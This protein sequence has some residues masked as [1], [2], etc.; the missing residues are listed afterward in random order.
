MNNYIDGGLELKPSIESFDF[1]EKTHPVTNFDPVLLMLSEPSSVLDLITGDSLKGFIFKLNVQDGKSSY[2][3]FNL[4]EKKQVEV[5]HFALKFVVISDTESSLDKFD[6]NNK[7]T[8][9]AE[10]FKTEAKMQQEIWKQTYLTYG[11]E[12]APSVGNITFLE[13][14]EDIIDLLEY[15]KDR[16]V[17]TTQ[18]AIEVIDYLKN[19]YE[20]NKGFKLGI[21]L[22]KNYENSKPYYE[23]FE[24][25]IDLLNTSPADVLLA[26]K[27]KYL[28]IRQK[29]LI[30]L[31]R[32][33][34][35]G[36]IHLD[37]H[38]GNSLNTED[39]CVIIDYGKAVSIK[40]DN[41]DFTIDKYKRYMLNK[42]SAW[43]I[44]DRFVYVTD[45]KTRVSYYLRRVKDSF[46]SLFQ[47]LKILEGHVKKRFKRVTTQDTVNLFDTI[48]KSIETIDS[49]TYG[50]SF[51]DFSSQ[52]ENLIDNFDD[53]E[54][55]NKSMDLNELYGGDFA[56]RLVKEMKYANAKEPKKKNRNIYR[57]PMVDAATVNANILGKKSKRDTRSWAPV[58]N[59]HGGKT[60]KKTASRIVKS[61][62]HTN[63]KMMKIKSSKSKSKKKQI[64]I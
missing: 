62:F 8:D 36:Y 7:E 53:D 4:E 19:V 56:K 2:T 11:G 60:I 54:S 6:G 26:A 28:N 37:F 31:L 3:E 30:K 16:G 13:G 24:E 59:K 45:R 52:M 32:L 64:S 29:T 42:N 25:Y 49:Y 14:S 17:N 34:L 18:E 5:T 41:H 61:K 12:I 55:A 57:I 40:K 39:S 21:L 35:L 50:Y 9:T 27:K 10:L 1:D 20:I 48:I 47:G 51:R 33:A 46:D 15:L 38:S 22:M 23:Y 63:K 43:D 44:D 58:F